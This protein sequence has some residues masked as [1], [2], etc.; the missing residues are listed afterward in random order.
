LASAASFAP[1]CQQYK[2]VSHDIRNVRCRGKMS[3]ASELIQAEPSKNKLLEAAFACCASGR[4]YFYSHRR[5]VSAER[6]QRTKVHQTQSRLGVL[7]RLF[8]REKQLTG[9]RNGKVAFRIIC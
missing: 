9:K 5:T 1:F 4:K 7:K 2:T 6:N 3:D 8:E